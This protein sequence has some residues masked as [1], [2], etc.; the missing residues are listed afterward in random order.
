M[1]EGLLER[2]VSC[3]KVMDE[4][5]E[6]ASPRFSLR[7]SRW[8]LLLLSGALEDNETRRSGSLTDPTGSL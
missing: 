3:P 5:N 2:K 6:M 1:L 8:L 4:D 7:L